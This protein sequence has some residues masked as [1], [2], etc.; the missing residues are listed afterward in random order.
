V[1]ARERSFGG[2]FLAMFG[3]GSGKMPSYTVDEVTK[4]LGEKWQT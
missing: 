1:C 4:G 3:Q 2:G